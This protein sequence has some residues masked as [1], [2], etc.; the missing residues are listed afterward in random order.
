MI[1]RILPVLLA[2][3]PLAAA[4]TITVPGDFETIQEAV[5]AAQAGDTVVVKKGVYPGTVTFFQREEIVLR[6]KGKPVI[7]ATRL[8]TGLMIDD[9][10]DIEVSGFV[11]QNPLQQGIF[12]RMSLDVSVRQC[13][14]L[15][16]AATAGIVVEQSERVLL[17]KNR[18]E[19]TDAVGILLQS[20]IGLGATDSQVLRNQVLS[21]AGS[22]IALT[23]PGNLIDRNVI[24]ECGGIGIL[25]DS[26]S[27]NSTVSRNKV[28]L[29][30]FT[31]IE[32]LSGD[33]VL[34]ERNT[35]TDGEANGLFLSVV[36]GG[37]STLKNRIVRSKDDGITVNASDGELEG[38]SVIDAETNS[39]RISG[40]NN[41][42]TGLKTVRGAED[43]FQILGAGNDLTSC[44]ASAA[45]A[46]GF[47]ATGTSNTFTKCRA[48]GSAILDLNDA[49]NMPANTYVNC[50]FG[51]D[52]LP[53]P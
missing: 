49:G 29:A 48:K 52:N 44:K 34:I 37:V 18:V 11:V 6:G 36:A 23:G 12:V 51:T 4:D 42:L 9:S 31:G 38:D 14:V 47:S 24:D 5:D 19:G 32:V 35:I 7:D 41:V 10:S 28:L 45:G 16:G 40:N 2:L 3:A 15:E 30:T 8:G 21:V 43:G 25:L 50:K 26:M 39:I 22:G 1:P 53:A 27:E 20:G 13:A 46:S 33:G 17:E